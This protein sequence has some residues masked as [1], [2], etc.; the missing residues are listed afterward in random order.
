MLSSPRLR[1]ALFN[2]LSFSTLHLLEPELPSFALGSLRMPHPL[3]LVPFNVHA[4]F[5]RSMT[6]LCLLKESGN[7]KGKRFREY[8]SA[9]E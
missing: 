5:G 2:A 4:G 3:R 1:V 7:A 9:E 6:E 8:L